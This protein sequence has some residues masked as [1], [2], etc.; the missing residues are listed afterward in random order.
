MSSLT[1]A[2]P[3]PVRLDVKRGLLEEND[4]KPVLCFWGGSNRKLRILRLEQ[5]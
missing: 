3:P 2:I 5:A 1:A 4:I